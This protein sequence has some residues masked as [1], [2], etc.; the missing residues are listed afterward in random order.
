MVNPKEEMFPPCEATWACLNEVSKRER[1]RERERESERERGRGRE[2]G[3]R[4]RE[5]DLSDENIRLAS[6]LR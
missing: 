5:T 4:V 2:K 6:V 1:E 3:E